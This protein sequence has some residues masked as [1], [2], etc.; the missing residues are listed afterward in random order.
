MTG[1]ITE[2]YGL[3]VGVLS[4]SFVYARGFDSFRVAYTSRVEIGRP[5][6]CKGES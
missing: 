3:K 1:Q 5:K 6:L 2:F 4:S